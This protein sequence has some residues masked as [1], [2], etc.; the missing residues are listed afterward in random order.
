MWPAIVTTGLVHAAVLVVPVRFAASQLATPPVP[1]VLRFTALAE[2]PPP[3]PPPEPDAP[4][5]EPEPVET[6]KPEPPPPKPRRVTPSVE[7]PQIEAEPP[8]PPPV[9]VATDPSPEPHAIAVAPEIAPEPARALPSPVRTTSRPTEADYRGW[10]KGI[11]AALMGHRH[12]PPAAVRL[13]LEGVVKLR[14]HVDRRG[15]LLGE[16]EIVASSGHD[17]LDNE[18]IRAAKAAA[19]YAELPEDTLDKAFVIPIAFRLSHD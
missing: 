14:V 11:H 18:A 5:P 9:A 2:T 19:P 17:V 10:A 1:T 16:P 8:A 4:E 3:P 12:Y 15:R 7:K 6:A 13:G